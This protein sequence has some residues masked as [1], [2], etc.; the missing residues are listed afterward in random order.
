MTQSDSWCGSVL[1]ELL[2]G[3]EDFCFSEGIMAL[4]TLNCGKGAV[5]TKEIFLPPQSLLRHTIFSQFRKNIH[6]YYIN[7]KI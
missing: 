4:Q 6:I 7:S 3:L 1:W 5:I 2:M